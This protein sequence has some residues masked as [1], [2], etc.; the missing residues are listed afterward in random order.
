[1]FLTLL[2]QLKFL[3]KNPLKKSD[4]SLKITPLPWQSNLNRLHHQ[5][6]KP[7]INPFNNRIHKHLLK[8]LIQ[9]QHRHRFPW[10]PLHKNPP[11]HKN[12]PLNNRSN[13]ILAPHNN[14]PNRFPLYRMF[15]NLHSRHILIKIRY[16]FTNIKI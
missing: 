3:N 11:I 5:T 10:R 4:P 8:T 15:T 2:W 16:N 14:N 6:L 12:L 7:K 13:K 9:F 1:M